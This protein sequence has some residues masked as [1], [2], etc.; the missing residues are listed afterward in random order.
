[1]R[2]ETTNDENMMEMALYCD[3]TDLYTEEE[4]NID[5]ITY[6]DFPKEL[7]KQYF[8]DQCLKYF[9]N[10]EDI[11]DDAF[12]EDWLLEYTC[13]DTDGLYWYA[14]EHGYGARRV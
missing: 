13:D 10:D 6:L 2:Y 14:K 3:S 12:Y 1:M 4:C 11:S 7:V 9:R 8:M 5:N